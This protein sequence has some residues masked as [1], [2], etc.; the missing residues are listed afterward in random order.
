MYDMSPLYNSRIINVFLKYCII[1]YPDMDIDSVLADANMGRHEVEDPACWFSQRQVD[2]FHE[3]VVDKTGN[4][5]ISREAGRFAVSSDALG[6]LKEYTIGLMPLTSTFLF[7][8]KVYAVMSRASD[9][10]VKKLGNSK[11]EITNTPKPGIKEKPYQCENRIGTF[12]A[13][14]AFFTKMFPKIEHPECLH[15]GDK[16]CRYIIS[17][18]IPS[19]LKWKQIRNY[20]FILGLLVSLVL[21][22]FLQPTS[23]VISVLIFLL[24]IMATSYYSTCLEKKD[25][26][27]TIKNQGDTAEALLDEMNIRHNNALLVQTIGQAVS[28]DTD[29]RKIV[30]IVVNA[31][32]KHLDYDRGL[33]MFASS[34]KDHLFY[35]GGYGYSEEQEKIMRQTRFHL[36]KA[37]SRGAFVRAFKEQKPFFVHDLDEIKNNST[38]RTFGLA[39]QM[40]V[41]SLICVPISYEK[42][43][44]GILAVDNVESK[45][46][47]KKSDINLLTGVASQTAAAIVNAK[48]FR[49]IKQ[50]EKKYRELVENA[51]SII[52]RGDIKGNIVFFNE[53]AQ[54]FFGYDGNE[55]IGRNVADILFPDTEDAGSK[56]QRL[57]TLFQQ[58]PERK[59]VSEERHF[60]SNGDMVWVAWTYKPIFNKSGDLEEILGIGN[61][62]TEIKKAGLEREK[63]E[64]RL[65]RAQKMEAIGMLAGGVA[66]DL[67]NI[68]SAIIGYPELLLLDLPEDSP[69]RKPLMTIKK[70]GEKAAAVVQDLLTL[71][72]RGVV[73]AEVLSLNDVVSAY[74]KSPEHEQLQL[75][76]PE[77]NFKTI[78]EPDLLSISGSPAHLSATLMNLLHN[79]AESITDEGEIII[80]LKNRYIDT[81]IG[82]YDNIREGDYVVLAIADNGTG[83]ASKDMERIFEPFFTKKIMGRG[84]TGLGMAIVWGIV[85]DHNG[86]IEVKS[87]EG[88]GTVFRLYFPAT[89]QEI[90]GAASSVSLDECMGMGES[91]L[92]VD[93]IPE[94]KELAS[95]MLKK[96]G[97]SVSSVS[98]GEEAID[99]IK[100]NS[101][102]LLVLD[103]IMEPGMDGLETYRSILELCPGQKAVIA[104]GFS[105]NKHVKEAQRLGAGAYVRKPYLLKEIG[106]AVRTE[107]KNP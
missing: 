45:R 85:K 98:S 43:S 74:L 40:D 31:M 54:K 52:L 41:R 86:Y 35:A 34:Q 102:D 83:I 78:L 100:D 26:A 8:D 51:N 80:S 60:N 71:S 39:K 63:L 23:W 67:N 88:K 50:E 17:W 95:G 106:V 69:I 97:Y 5:N 12:E 27:R 92:V 11:V 58:Y 4:P 103:M 99:F 53:F 57:V 55:V 56:R 42:E 37:A 81:P 33:I 64:A 13:T 87:I 89:R 14:V 47:L 10:I 25:L 1:N 28:R 91:I 65:Q 104:S 18:K 36:D 49:K 59:I 96:L 82:E 48:S 107:L 15:K 77:V 68:L 3:A 20:F 46:S 76:H 22:L 84:G 29:V 6:A 44:M 30:D 79:A 62:V 7:M 93:D 32:G 24:L 101:V 16:C 38:E 66:H 2:D 19:F 94:Q 73:A 61:D 21:L 90:S 72:R 70:S 75:D 105:E 9:V